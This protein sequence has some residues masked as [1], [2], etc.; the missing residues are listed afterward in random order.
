LQGGPLLPKALG[1]PMPETLPDLSRLSLEEIA[2]LSAEHKLP[3][4]EQWSPA[5]SGESEMRIARDGTWY[6]QGSPIRRENMVRLFS[7]ILRRE[8]D[9]RYVLVTPA[10]KLFIEVED[11]PF[12][13]V[14]VKS[15]GQGRER[16]LAFRMNTGD[17]VV[18]GAEHPLTFGGTTDAP[19]PTLLVR[20]GME[21]RVERT[22]FYAL[23]DWAIEE[24]QDPMGL[25]S[26][27]R[28]F[29]MAGA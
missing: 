24:A 14:E 22:A 16:R 1:M 25:W 29:A 28:F 13:A 17:L 6:H 19:H 2:Q 9:G 8:D 7:T 3:P 20:G 10:E 18:A 5:K 15:E 4:V 21:A 23:A 27:G 12:I 26:D 11:T